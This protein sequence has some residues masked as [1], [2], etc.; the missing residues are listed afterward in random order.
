MEKAEPPTQINDDKPKEAESDEYTYEYEEEVEETPKKENSKQNP[1]KTE[2]NKTDD[3]SKNDITPQNYEMGRKNLE[4]S[5]PIAI[6]SPDRTSPRSPKG[7]LLTSL[8][9]PVVSKSKTTGKKSPNE[10]NSPKDSQKKQIKSRSTGPE[11]NSEDIPV[12]DLKQFSETDYLNAINLILKN[13]QKPEPEIYQD[14]LAY[15]R[16][17]LAEATISEDYDTCEEMNDCIKFL[18][19]NNENPNTNSPVITIEMRIDQTKQ[20]IADINEKYDKKLVEFDQQKAMKMVELKAAHEAEMSKIEEQV[21]QPEFLHQFDKPSAK[22]Q[23]IRVIQKEKAI[24][25]DFAGAKE[26]KR[27]G[28]E[29]QKKETEMAKRKVIEKIELL[30]SKQEEKHEIAVKCAKQNWERKRITIEQER[31]AELEPLRMLLSQME[32]K[33]HHSIKYAIKSRSGAMQPPIYAPTQPNV[34]PRT[35]RSVSNYKRKGQSKLNLTD[36]EPAKYV[37]AKTPKTA[38]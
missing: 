16:R 32:N 4:T 27:I 23:Q 3:F 19:E 7:V 14:V 30:T 36:F 5:P 34:T 10:K 24:M 29:L 28:D 22:L 8:K 1:E 9:S 18:E 35:M 31:E 38:K 25:K 21:S 13:K 15:S 2:L 37:R 6:F 12:L 11:E 20:S 17:R 26:Y 33:G